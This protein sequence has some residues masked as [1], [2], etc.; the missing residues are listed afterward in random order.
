MHSSTYPYMSIGSPDTSADLLRL[1]GARD[2]RT[3][4]A[5]AEQLGALGLGTDAL[6]A[7]L[8]D[9][10]SFVRSAATR[11]LGNP[12]HPDR[13]AIIDDLRGCIHDPN[14]HVAAAAVYALGRIG[15]TEAIGDI[16]SYIDATS[17]VV[18][19][20][21]VRALGSLEARAY[22]TPIAA[23][24]DVPDRKLRAYTIAVLHRLAHKESAPR[25]H[26]ILRECLD[27]SSD[28]LIINHAIHALADFEHTPAIPVLTEIARTRFGHRTR[29]VRALLQ[30]K[31]YE[32][33][34]SLVSLYGEDTA[35]LPQALTE[36]MIAADHRA[37]LPYIRPLLKHALHPV[38]LVALKAIAM[39]QDVQSRSNV[40][41]MA[42]HEGDPLLASQAMATWYAFD[43]HRAERDLVG[44]VQGERVQIARLASMLLR[45]HGLRDVQLHDEVRTLAQTLD[46]EA[47][48]DNLRLVALR[49]AE[50]AATSV[51][52]HTPEPP[53]TNREVV[54][55]YLTTWW[56]GVSAAEGEGSADADLSASLAAVLRALGQP[57]GEVSARTPTSKAA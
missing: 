6:R 17:P 5:A 15:A 42:L 21:A 37:A 18:R 29:A 24:L 31:A 53:T 48:C 11:G 19:L 26:E 49:P 52:H 32:V 1:V 38:R 43:P 2:P 51:A 33:A 44:L 56:Q 54:A 40:R 35:N 10:N 47:I 22:G 28:D 27:Q 55:A 13:D 39:W 50:D 7:A 20:A 30:L 25:I 14:D 12:A 9:R 8:R 36:L 34:P 3:R 46:D 57:A 45:D 41:Y 16:A 23:M 4:T